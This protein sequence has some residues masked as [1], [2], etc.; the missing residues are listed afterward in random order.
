ME[1]QKVD[2]FMM[3]SSKYF[4]A[5]QLNGIREQLL[6]LDESKWT[7]VQG[8]QLKD[9]TTSLIISIVA[10]NLG[11]DRFYIGDTGMGIGKLLTCGGFMIWTIVD[12]FLI[13]GITRE[14]N[15]EA[16]QNALL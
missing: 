2:L 7:L 14:K 11:I 3:M 9:P 15:M 1:A 6:G 5:H 4:E 13:M 12:W 10:G 8:I 16:F